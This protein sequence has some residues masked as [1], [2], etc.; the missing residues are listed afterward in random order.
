MNQNEQNLSHT[1]PENNEHEI[2][3]AKLDKMIA[4]HIQPWPEYKQVTHTTQQAFDLHSKDQS[5]QSTLSLSGRLIIKRDHGK[6]FFGIIQDRASRLQIYLKKDDLGDAAFEHF[7]KYIDIG[8]IIW[9]SGSMFTTKMGEAT[10]K[11]DSFTLLSKCL[12]PLPEK[13][14]GLTDVEQRYRQRYLDL[15][16]NP[17]SK[18]KFKKRSLIVQ[19]IRNFLQAHDFLEVETPMLHPI[20]GGAA[21]HPF[22]THHNAYNM[23][24]YLRIAP[25]LYLKRLVI[26]GFERVFEI[27]RNFRNEGIS[28]RHNPEFTM[29]EFYMAHG[30]YQ[31]GMHLTE[32]LI[33]D[34]VMKNFGTTKV[35][36]QG[37][38]IDFTAPF[39]RL[40]VAESLIELGG[41][42]KEQI[43]QEGIDV[44]IKENNIEVHKGADYGVKLF[45]LFEFFVESKIVQPTFIIGYPI[46][47]SPLAKRDPNNPN[48]AAR[49]ELFM[50]GMEFANGFT[51]LNDP[52]DQAERFKAQVKAREGGDKEAHYYDADYIKALEYGLA[53]A[54]GV[55]IGIDR[56]VMLL[57]DTSSIKDV[58]LFPTLKLAHPGSQHHS[59]A[60]NVEQSSTTRHF[61]V[62]PKMFTTFNNPRIALTLVKNVNNSSS[63]DVLKKML[64][65]MSKQVKENYSA[66]TLTQAPA[67]IGWRD[68]YKAFGSKPSEFPSSVENLYK[69]IIKGQEINSVNPLV[70]IYN[71][72]S[73]KYMLPAGGEDL[74]IMQGNLQLTFATADEK[75]VTVLGKN[76][77]EKPYAGEVIY[78]DATET[79]CRR[80]NWREVK[81]TLLTDTTKNAILVLEAIGSVPTTTLQNA[82]KELA[83]LVKLHCGGEVVTHLINKD[84]TSCDIELK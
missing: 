16:S 33:L 53:P 37:K 39:K 46:E 48:M 60:H 57:T 41:L 18:E 51:E 61:S 59:T 56:L 42:S 76:E 47:V 54:V 30:D 12:H 40:T 1:A 65:D 79:I 26:G 6:T 14:H 5:D 84:N 27:N 4:D 72:I 45:S 19:T 81:R 10:L 31:T 22:V 28:T 67:I 78:K 66:E 52:F 80:W 3:V 63:T 24:L 17:E 55:G 62:N 21:A 49:F 75:P 20:P 58:I 73:L 7:K 35:S 32:Q 50:C 34:A 70:D 68:A 44:L 29:L 77:A 83:E 23:Q 64:A 38:L 43:S 13:F 36:F 9:V 8:D 69:R 15:I 11:V 82:Q 71:Y 25:E 74:D 2:R